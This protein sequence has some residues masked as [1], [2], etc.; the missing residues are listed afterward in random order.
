M[1]PRR[2]N[3]PHYFALAIVM[4][5]AMAWLPGAAVLAPPWHYAGAI[6]LACG[7]AI[8]VVAS[9]QFA[10]VGTNIV[11]LTRSSVLVT[12]GAFALTRNP[13]Y[14]GMVLALI[15]IALLLNGP[16]PWLVPCGFV[17]LLYLHFIRHEEALMAQTFGD[18]YLQYKQRVRRWV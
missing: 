15:G 13:M 8:A 11:P 1:S 5:I 6:V 4:M 2:I 12:N 17:A 10:V 16:W 3:P 14:L 9:R 7:V 18:A